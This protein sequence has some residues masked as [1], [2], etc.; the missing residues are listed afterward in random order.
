MLMGLRS[1]S[2]PLRMIC[3]FT[4]I[5]DDLETPIRYFQRT[6]LSLTVETDDVWAF[7]R[8]FTRCGRSFPHHDE[9]NGFDDEVACMY[10]I[11]LQVVQTCDA[12]AHLLYT[13]Y[14]SQMLMF[15]N[16]CLSYSG[17]RLKLPTG[18]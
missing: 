18:T 12:I 14:Y 9:A 2:L 16:L 4:S 13:P 6:L 11:I 3:E 7:Y 5:R 8:G 1:V 10:D 15:C 17:P